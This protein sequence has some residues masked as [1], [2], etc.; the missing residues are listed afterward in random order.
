[1]K[2]TSFLYRRVMFE[3]G[4]SGDVGRNRAETIDYLAHPLSSMSLLP[5]I[6]EER[7]RIAAPSLNRS[8]SSDP[9]GKTEGDKDVGN[10]FP[11]FTPTFLSVYL[12]LY[13]FTVSLSSTF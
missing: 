1:M 7:E 8:I 13:S 4:S 9:S 11:T 5:S 2:L 6:A 10:S 3:M 12:F